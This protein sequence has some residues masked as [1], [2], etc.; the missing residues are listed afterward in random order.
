MIYFDNARR[1]EGEWNEPPDMALDLVLA[2]GN[3]HNTAV[4]KQHSSQ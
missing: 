1:D 3:L 2:S 4:M